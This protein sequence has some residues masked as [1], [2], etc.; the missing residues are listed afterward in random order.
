[1]STGTAGGWSTDGLGRGHLDS[2]IE[3]GIND[4]GSG[5]ATALEV[6]LQMAELGT[7]TRNRVRFT[8]WGA[9][10]DG[11]IGSQHYVDSLAK[12]EV[13]DLML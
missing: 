5:S 4:N 3:P 8:F 10:E 2:P 9:E 13:K 12:S 1:M 11:L 6:A 7:E